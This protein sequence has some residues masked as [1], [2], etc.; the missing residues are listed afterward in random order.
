MAA[1]RLKLWVPQVDP[2]DP[3]HVDAYLLAKMQHKQRVS[4]Q[5]VLANI[6]QQ[7]FAVEKSSTSNAAFWLAPTTNFPKGLS[8]EHKQWLVTREDLASRFEMPDDGTEYDKVYVFSDACPRAGL[9]PWVQKL[10]FAL[11]AGQKNSRTTQFVRAHR[12]CPGNHLFE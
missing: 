9:G 12:I 1:K 8:A 10:T 4:L 6:K 3:S 2:D 11:K 7:D 5:A